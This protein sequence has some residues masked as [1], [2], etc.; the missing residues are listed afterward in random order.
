[1]VPL[2]DCWIIEFT[3]NDVVYNESYRDDDIVFQKEGRRS[4]YNTGFIWMKCNTVV[5]ELFTETLHYLEA[6]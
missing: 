1:M 6:R 4:G 5:H 2:S 3:D